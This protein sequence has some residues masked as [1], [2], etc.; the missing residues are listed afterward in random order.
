MFASTDEEY[1][2]Q[3][4]GMTI[5]DTKMMNLGDFYGKLVPTLTLQDLFGNK[6]QVFVFCDAE[7]NGP[8]HLSMY[9][10]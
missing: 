2:S 10:F 4:K 8:G 3:L 7:E 1:Y 6:Y 9:E 5:I